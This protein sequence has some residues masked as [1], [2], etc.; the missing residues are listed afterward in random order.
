MIDVCMARQPPS[1]GSQRGLEFNALAA[2]M[3]GT[4]TGLGSPPIR[5]SLISGAPMAGLPRR[6]LLS[7]A[8][9]AGLPPP[10]P[11]YDNPVKYLWDRG[12]HGI[13]RFIATHPDMDH[14]DGITEIFNE[15]QPANFWDTGNTKQRPS[16]GAFR[17]N[18]WMTYQQLRD[19]TSSYNSKRLVLHSGAQGRFFN[20]SGPSGEPQDGLHVLA[21]TNALTAKANLTGDY[22]DASYVILYCSDA[23]RILFCGDSH[24][25]TWDHL[26]KNHIDSIRNVELMI[27]PHHGRDSGRDWSFL[28]HVQ[29]RLTLF[30]RAPS[31]YLAY[32]AWRNRNLDYIT[33]NQAGSIVIDTN[34][35]MMQIY[36]SNEQFA[37]KRN[38]FAH[39]SP[40]HRA[41]HIATV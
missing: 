41:W 16:P 21:P 33:S 19:G 36:V 24:D 40:D 35:Q 8:M 4:A 12:I 32:D 29:P 1:T 2:A 31:E 18:D 3:A 9:M 13:F 34:S 22:N 26:I 10:Q 5:R 38:M 11:D 30:G 7:A 37:K 28:T 23:G 39:Y 27:A 17:D 20:E 25:S 14:I 6:S 15:F